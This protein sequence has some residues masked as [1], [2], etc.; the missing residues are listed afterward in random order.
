[1]CKQNEVS[2]VKAKSRSSHFSLLFK[3]LDVYG[4]GCLHYAC[5]ILKLNFVASRSLLVAFVGIE[6]IRN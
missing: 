2:W 6:S 1:M 4:V 3:L 5:R